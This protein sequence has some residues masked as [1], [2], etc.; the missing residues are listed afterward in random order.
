MTKPTLNVERIRIELSDARLYA[1]SATIELS[2]DP[3]DVERLQTLIW[4]TRNRI[5][6]IIRR[7]N[8]GN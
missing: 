6:R 1:D 2:K 3:L 5:A 7:I 8:D 4:T